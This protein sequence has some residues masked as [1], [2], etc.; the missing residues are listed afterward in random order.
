MVCRRDKSNRIITPNPEK[1][2]FETFSHLTLSGLEFTFEEGI[3]GITFEKTEKQI[4]K[5]D[6]FLDFF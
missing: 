6:M 5:K 1:V 4:S 2:S 3:T